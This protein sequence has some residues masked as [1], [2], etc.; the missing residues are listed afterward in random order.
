MKKKSLL[1]VFIG[2]ILGIINTCVF[3]VGK[4]DTNDLSGTCGKIRGKIESIVSYKGS[5]QQFDL[6]NVYIDTNGNVYYLKESVRV[7][8]P[9]FPFL[10]LGDEIE[11][12]A[13]LEKSEY[14]QYQSSLE[15]RGVGYITIARTHVVLDTIDLSIVNGIKNHCIESIEYNFSEP[16]ASILLG[17]NWGVKRIRGGLWEEKVKQSG[18][19][20][21]FSISGYHIFIISDFLNK[22]AIKF[23]KLSQ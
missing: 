9:L 20:Y 14:L 17:F 13:C 6:S 1:Y 11:I 12:N 18:L 10:R 15:Q 4:K 3:I 16:Y 5:F 2:L 7:T 19:A 8:V 21:L 23:V 22:I